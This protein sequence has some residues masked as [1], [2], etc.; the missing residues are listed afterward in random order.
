MAVEELLDFPFILPEMGHTRT[1]LDRILLPH[2]RQLKVAFEPTG[3]VLVKRLVAAGMGIT[4]IGETYAEE[5]SHRRQVEA[6]AVARP[7]PRPR[8]RRGRAQGLPVAGGNMRPDF[9]R[10]EADFPLQTTTHAAGQHNTHQ[11]KKIRIVRQISPE[12]Q[13]SF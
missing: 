8:N 13:A 3:I 1:A 6:G 5:G 12:G 4:I 9:C 7:P 2:R 11:Q 10:P